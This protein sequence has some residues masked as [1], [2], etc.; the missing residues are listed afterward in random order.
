MGDG[1]MIAA[2]AT[3]ATFQ[4]TPVVDGIAGGSID[5]VVTA[6]TSGFANTTATVSVTNV[7]TAALLVTPTTSAVRE[8]AGANVPFYTV[9]RNTADLTQ[10]L[11]VNLLSSN[12]QRLGVPSSVTIPIGTRSIFFQ[13]VPVNDTV[14][15]P[16]VDVTLTASA[17]GFATAIWTVTVLDDEATTPAPTLT[18]TLSV[19]S[20]NE[21]A[22]AGST[23]LTV[24]RTAG[25][26]TQALLVNLT[27]SH[28]SRV[29]GPATITIP[30][31][32]TSAIVP[33]STINNTIVDGNIAEDITATAAGFVSGQTTLQVQDDD[34]AT[35]TITPAAST[36]PETV[37][38][39][40]GIVT[41]SRSS[42]EPIVVRMSYQVGAVLT[43][44]AVVVIPAG[45]TSV[46]ITFTVTN[47]SVI[48]QN[49]AAGIAADAFGTVS[50]EATVTV[51]DADTMA[52]TATPTTADMVQSNGTIITRNAVA[53]VTGTTTAGATISI[54]S[55][56]DG[57][58]DNGTATAGNDGT[59]SVNVNV[60]NTA[61]NHGENRIVVRA[62]SGANSA[63]T[64]V[65]VHRAV[66]TVVHF[67]TNVGAY[68]VEL[69]DTAAPLAVA[70]FLSYV[71][72]GA[73]QNSIVHRSNLNVASGSD[74]VNFIQ[75]G[76]FTV[77]N[78]HVTAITAGDSIMNQ[79][80]AAN[81]NVA[82]TLATAL[83]GPPD[84]ATSGWFINTTDNGSAF[85]GGLYTVFGRVIGNG[86]T[87]VQ[88]ISNL[89]RQNLNSLYPAPVAGNL[90]T[91]PLLSGFTLGGTAITGVVSTTSGSTILTGTG[92]LFT[93]QLAVGESITIG[94]GQAFFISA[95][96][97]NT[98]LTLTQAFPST[99]SSQTVRKDV[100]PTD[101]EFVVFSDIGTILDMP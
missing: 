55:D 97:S 45:A 7:D 15:N 54:D 26:T 25:D 95:I 16:G 46:P 89:P 29:S 3:S 47:D 39:V 19:A 27:Y 60:T 10:A 56:G 87:V 23:F 18:A 71:T 91:T 35:L 58:F 88:Q 92:T 68:D 9:S 59:Y 42:S 74:P 77:A 49:V 83:T 57:V 38:T 85:D 31:A 101:A 79:F 44:P 67:A 14:V 69:L 24:T 65:G 75:G 5:V 28:P 22:S 40:A 99:A 84:T 81:S 73:Y 4:G 34:T 96:S 41:T 72:S 13:V 2:N 52:L 100:L 32:Q 30:A 8:N 78:S 37:G 6:S 21:S 66:G 61:A 94:S 17:S 50:A 12:T 48:V 82:G 20:L 36:V 62:V 43:G 1:V 63:D 90:T 76:G 53:Q 11:T 93:T 64:A 86:L 33:L 70:N 80:L 51:T 98:S